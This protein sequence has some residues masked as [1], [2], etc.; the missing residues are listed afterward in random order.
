MMRQGDLVVRKS[1]GGDLLFKVEALDRQKA[2]LKGVEFRLLADS[3][4]NDLV[5]VDDLKSHRST[6]EFEIRTRESTRLLEM[7]KRLQ[8]EKN[9]SLMPSMKKKRDEIPFFELPGKILHLDGDP[10]YLRKS[11]SVYNQLNMPA[12]GY[13][14]SEPNMAQAVYQLLPNVKPDILVITGH[15]GLH[16]NHKQSEWN[17]L[18]SYKN[19]V[20]F[21]NAVKIARQY[22]RNRDSLAIIAGACQSHFEALLH[23]GANFASSPARILIHALDP[24]YI[25]AKI[26]YTSIKETI[27]IYDV[28]NNTI[29]GMEGLGGIETRGSYRIGLP[30]LKTYS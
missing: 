4:L 21:V 23:S 27:N 11:M 18:N 6:S 14:V 28:I 2:I 29:S 26:S 1:Y 10:I 24:A 25:A 13:Y 30:K 19:S 3:P 16:K 15:D 20:N 7:Y 8:R 17:D 9:E 5:Q 12:E 22:E